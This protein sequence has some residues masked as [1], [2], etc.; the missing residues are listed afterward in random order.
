MIRA[1][2]SSQYQ[3]KNWRYEEH[4]WNNGWS[5]WTCNEKK[6]KLFQW[7]RK[8]LTLLPFQIW[9]SLLREVSRAIPEE[10]PPQ[11]EKSLLYL[12]LTSWVPIKMKAE[13]NTNTNGAAAVEFN[14]VL[15]LFSDQMWSSTGLL[16]IGNGINQ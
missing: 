6:T 15:I 13:S 14:W 7:W 12:L 9:K 3:P 10:K 4:E 8:I 11:T 1:K 5:E 2:E 16:V